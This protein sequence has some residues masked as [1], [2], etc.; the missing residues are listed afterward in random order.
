LVVS[1]NIAAMVL[2]ILLLFALPLWAQDAATLTPFQGAKARAL[3]KNQLPCLGCHEI[4]GDGGRIAPSLTN[5]GERRGSAYIR[6]MIEDPQ[7][8]VA[9]AAMPKTEMP[10]ATRELIIRY[11]IQR[12][13]PGDVSPVVPSPSSQQAATAPT[14][15]AKWCASCHGDRGGGDGPNARYLPIPP[16]VHA[17]ASAMSPRSDDALFDII[18]GGGI[19]GGKSPRMPA[20][21]TT[22]TPAEI[23]SLVAHI[24]MLCNCEGPSWSRDG[25]NR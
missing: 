6:A 9:G 24:R 21:G 18:A 12:A 1:A 16:A 17:T 19:V 23:R 14:L 15:Y 2:W 25:S 22:L 10:T 3:L 13:Q 7:R 4:E 11:L 20:F 8:V 5:V